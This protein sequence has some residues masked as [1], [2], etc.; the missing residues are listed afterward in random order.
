LHTNVINISSVVIDGC[1]IVLIILK[2]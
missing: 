1:V 2:M